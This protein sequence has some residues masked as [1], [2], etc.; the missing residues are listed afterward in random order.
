VTRIA[1]LVISRKLPPLLDVR[2]V[3][4]DDIRVELEIKRD[5]DEALV[6]AY[7]CRHTPLQ[8]S[9]G[10]NLTCLIPTEQDDIG[11]PER[12]DLKAMLW[13]FLHFRMEVVSRR[14]EHEAATLARRIHI[15]VGFEKVFD[16]LDQ[17]L[18]IVRKSDGKADAATK[19]IAK[20]GLDAEQA[21]AILELKIYRLA[22]LEILIIQ[23]ELADKRERQAEIRTLLDDEPGRWGLVRGEIAEVQKL[24]SDTRADRR[25]TSFASDDE[26]VEYD[27]DAFIIEEDNVVLVSRDGWVKRQKDVKDPATTRLREGDEVLAAVGGSTRA[28]VVFF[29]THGVAYTSR[30]VDVPASTGYGEPI[31]RLFKF[32]DGERVVAVMS[33]DPRV[34]PDL[35]PATEGDTPPRHAL[36]AT[37]DGYALRFSLAGF[38]EPSTRAG[39]RFVKAPDGV[40][41]VGVVQ[42]TGEETIIAATR[43]ARA[44]LCPVEEVNV[45]S[46]P[47][48]GVILIKIDEKKDRLLG[49]I[50]S[51][52]AEQT[53]STAKYDVT[54]RGG[55]GR[56][57]LQRGSFTRIVPPVPVVVGPAE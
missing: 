39:R 27:A 16:A 35:Q 50:A 46:G 26:V 40:E 10:V 21:D 54:S 3:S 6:M 4:T 43:E 1:D 15:L 44:M 55:K 36:A 11:R 9:L 18:E 31:Q 12:L 28:S 38:V 2:D 22:R 29:T 56:E 52:G 17:I 41:V 51:R 34:S 7:L 45:L 47:G 13:H 37:S 49:F 14:L 5:A 25:R 19:I 57:L 30:I 48:R 53:I 8:V 42:V 32:R 24:Y 33:L 20:F 23:R